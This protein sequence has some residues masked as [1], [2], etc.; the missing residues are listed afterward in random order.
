MINRVAVKITRKQPY[1]DWANG[2]DGPVPV[3]T[4]PADNPHTIYLAPNDGF[5]PVLAR[6][7]DEF[8]EHV[9]EVEL[10]MW[11]VDETTWPEPRTRQ[12]FDEW[13]D[14]EIVDTVID[15]VPEEP[16]S[17]GEVEKAEIQYALSHCAWCDLEL[18]P[19]NRRVV[20]LSLA[21]RAALASR[22]GL[23]VV[24][25]SSDRILTGIMTTADS[26]AASEGHD[27]VFSA[28]SSRCEKIIR[29]EAV[30]GLRQ[31]T[32]LWSSS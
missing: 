2:T 4:Y 22:E 20:S 18:E 24:I 28:C 1:M 8:W 29:K 19:E 12:M 17:E 23:T 26:P 32:K 5:E 14:A 30:R 6:L 9:F 31:A 16:L 27:L 10:N 7:I 3:V 11:M 15:L 25:P 13:F 21:D